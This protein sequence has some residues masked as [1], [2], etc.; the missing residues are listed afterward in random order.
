MVGAIIKNKMFFII[1]GLLIMVG[2]FI[3]YI[4]TQSRNEIPSKGV[5]VIER[6]K[7]FL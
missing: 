6:D 7:E 5:F 2:V 1:L 4:S 3:V